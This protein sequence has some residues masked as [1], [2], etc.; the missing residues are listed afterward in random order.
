MNDDTSR[1]P[2]RPTPEL[3]AE[4]ALTAA[5]GLHTPAELGARYGIDPLEVERL[6]QRLVTGASRLFGPGE[7]ADAERERLEVIARCASD[8]HALVDRKGRLI[9]TNQFMSEALG[10]E[11][12]QLQVLSIHEISPDLTLE[13]FAMLFERA[14]ST[15]IARFECSL[16]RRDGTAF[17]V[18][19]SA[20]TV[21]LAA[22]P[23]LFVAARD[24]TERKR[25][26]QALRDSEARLRLVLAAAELG[27]WEHDLGTGRIYLDERAQA[28]HG[29]SPATSLEDIAARIH[30]DDR[31]RVAQEIGAAIDPAQRAPV[32]T[33]YRVVHDDGA[34]RWLRV[35]GR[36]EFAGDGASAE[37]LHGRG[38]VQ[39]V[40]DLRCADS[41]LRD[42]EVRYRTLFDSMAEG[43]C[44][45]EM[46]YDGAGRAVDYRFIETNAAFARHTGLVG[47]DGKT[48][49]ELVPE[50]EQHWVDSYGRVAATG[51]SHVFVLGS[52]AMD[53]W[54]EVEAFRVGDPENRRVALLFADVS[55]RRAAEESLRQ[56]TATLEERVAERTHQAQQLARRLTIAE[57]EERRRISQILHDDLQQ[58]LY[59]VQLKITMVQRT[60]AQMQAAPLVQESAQALNWLRQAVDV[61]R[62]LT[63]D[64]SPP[65]LK[66]EGL[67]VSL[68][69]LQ[70]QMRELHGLEVEVVAP[71]PFHMQDEGLR[72][73]LFQSVRELLFN[74]KKH[75]G[76]QHAR[77]EL[78]GEPNEQI[79]IRVTDQGTGFQAERSDRRE[80]EERFGLYNV[81]ERLRLIGG[82]MVVDSTPAQGTCVTIRAPL[83]PPAGA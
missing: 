74:V 46:I 13:A 32:S 52:D 17:P 44:V 2:G 29:A 27:V 69:W 21:T 83:A 26:E 11:P 38:T 72:V 49:R 3:Q 43:F 9:W 51:E 78:A 5:R 16:R 64:L 56:L 1:T 73:L 7:P 24:T 71:H 8:A 47:A 58:L 61:T 35:Q 54:F 60:L 53:R 23:S 15:R 22:G 67:A 12:E 41:A 40:T 75:A 65:I 50:L 31:S 39:D 76:V 70:R 42:S 10:R 57:Q 4:I 79:V 81:R 36:V 80:Q 37:P 14:R 20:T 55:E 68:E 18:E 48:A 34:M 63:V 30:A 59:G 25:V 28:A 82:D 77:V 66:N 19:M 45:M 6:R 62:Q 33:E